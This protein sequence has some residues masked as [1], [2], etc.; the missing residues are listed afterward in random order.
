MRANFSD[1]MNPRHFV[2]ALLACVLAAGCAKKDAVSKRTADSVAAV[3]KQKAADEANALATLD[4]S[5]VADSTISAV[6]VTK[7]KRE[8]VRRLATTLMRDSHELRVA[9]AQTVQKTGKTPAFS[10]GDP[11]SGEA[12]I[13]LSLIKGGSSAADGL[14]LSGVVARDRALAGEFYRRQLQ[15]DNADLKAL[16]AKVAAVSRSHVEAVADIE[17][18]KR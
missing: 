6:I 14:F 4:A 18:M 8:E 12:G 13:T 15:T 3:A 5:L 9:T 17:G 11:I 2:V 10:Q 1:P 7:S 16:F